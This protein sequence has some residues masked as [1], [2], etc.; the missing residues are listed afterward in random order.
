MKIALTGPF[1]PYRGGISQYMQKLNT[2]LRSA[3]HETFLYSFRRQFPRW[4][5]PGESD[6]SPGKPFLESDCSYCLDSVN[7]FSWWQVARLIQS[8]QPDALVIPW[9]VTLFAPMWGSMSRCIHKQGIPTLFICHNVLPHERRIW[10]IPATRWALRYG[11]G[12]IVQSKEEKQK[13]AALLPGKAVEVV[14]HPVYDM[15]V[16][17]LISKTEARQKLG[18]SLD[19]PVLLFFG[20]IRPYKGL[21]NLLKAIS[22]LSGEIPAIKLIIAG[23]FWSD[24]TE[25]L[26]LMQD[27]K[28]E[29]NI[30]L[31]DR[32]IS[33][34][35]VPGYFSAADVLIAPYS[36]ISQSGVVQMAF[37]LGLPVIATRVGGLPDAID[38]G[39]TGL[40]VPPEDPRELASAIRYYYQS[41][42]EDR[43]RAEIARRDMRSGW[44]LLMKT[45]IE[46]IPMK[47]KL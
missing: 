45:L 40:L 7:P 21:K 23:E 5:Y 29:K 36:R 18:L 26:Q 34:Q 32:Y 9:W 25:Y 22:L 8:R 28:I 20:L 39:A 30:L 37:G 33:D 41:G 13:L 2:V 14:A 44:T 11:A 15:F 10:D 19:I 42:M 35:E 6:L 31:V 38:D 3:G 43:V 1:P 46:L 16:G 47:K 17:G 4:L 24:K 27:L 12:F